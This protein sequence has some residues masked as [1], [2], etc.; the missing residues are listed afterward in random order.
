MSG[1]KFRNCVWCGEMFDTTKGWY[2][3]ERPELCKVCRKDKS[4][5]DRFKSIIL[6]VK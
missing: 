6:D 4:I 5:K 2:K 3:G 1:N